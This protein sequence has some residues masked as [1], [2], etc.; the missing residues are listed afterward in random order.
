MRCLG[1]TVT[2]Y[3]VEGQAQGLEHCS[4]MKASWV[5]SKM[6]LRQH[7]VRE[8][9]RTL[10]VKFIPLISDDICLTID[11]TESDG[12]QP[13][14]EVS[15]TFTKISGTVVNRPHLLIFMWAELKRASPAGWWTLMFILL[16]TKGCNL[17]CRTVHFSTNLLHACFM[18]SILLWRGSSV[19]WKIPLN[20]MR[21]GTW[22]CHYTLRNTFL[23]L[24]CTPQFVCRGMDSTRCWKRSTGMLAHVD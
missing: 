3:S 2:S 19:G 1:P 6:L 21:V 8:E 24:S 23:I 20:P 16:V 11:W 15:H 18:Y 14:G 22:K 4:A 10:L 7:S 12:I 9:C 5:L 17:Q 13:S